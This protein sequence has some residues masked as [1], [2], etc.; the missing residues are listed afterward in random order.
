MIKPILLFV[1]LVF[2]VQ[3]DLLAQTSYPFK[4]STDRMLW[5][6]KVD[7]QQRKVLEKKSPLDESIELQISD[8]LIRR[9]E[10]PLI[11]PQS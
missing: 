9:V 11:S 5:H 3:P 4:V 6:D 10:L 2:C 7:A 1:S 8:A